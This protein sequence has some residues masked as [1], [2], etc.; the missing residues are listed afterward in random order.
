MPRSSALCTTRLV[1]SK[2]MRPAKLLQPSPTSDTASPDLPRLRSSIVPRT[3][4]R[5]A[6]YG[7]GGGESRFLEP[8]RRPRREHPATRRYAFAA[9]VARPRDL[10][11]E[12]V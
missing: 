4:L 7:A 6:D 2:S 11:N 5:G 8:P 1:A 9:N 3:S 12:I 10:V